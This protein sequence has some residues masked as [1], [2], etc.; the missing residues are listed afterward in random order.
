[1]I[2]RQLAWCGVLLVLATGANAQTLEHLVVDAPVVEA[3]SI[4]ETTT[5]TP[6]LF[7]VDRRPIGAET[8]AIQFCETDTTGAIVADGWRGPVYVYGPAGLSSNAYEDVSTPA[9]QEATAATGATLITA[10]NTANLSTR[11]LRQRIMDRL[12][13]D[14]PAIA[15]TVTGTPQ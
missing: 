15:G 10:L 3:V 9:C 5:V 7:E 13:A 6:C 8:I 11:S 14:C 4:P 2:R 1:M 12:I